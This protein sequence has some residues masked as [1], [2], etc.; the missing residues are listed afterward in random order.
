MFD[1]AGGVVADIDYQSFN[2]L[3]NFL[4]FRL[5]IQYYFEDSSSF[6]KREIVGLV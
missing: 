4:L 1:N 3:P 2:D 5:L 6:I